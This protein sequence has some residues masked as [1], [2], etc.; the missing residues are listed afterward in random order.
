MRLLVCITLTLV[1]LGTVQ[2]GPV[3]DELTSRRRGKERGGPMPPNSRTKENRPDT[4]DNKIV[5]T[6]PAIGGSVHQ[7]VAMCQPAPLSGRSAANWGPPG[8]A[9]LPYTAVEPMTTDGPSYASML[10]Q[11]ATLTGHCCQQTA[12]ICSNC[13]ARL[14]EAGLDTCECV[15]TATYNVYERIA[16][17]ERRNPGTI[18]KTCIC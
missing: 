4:G 6:G 18:L 11:G 7:C 14:A 5:D 16:E 17:A 15:G 12:E 13:A 10:R 3:D 1:I 9:G 2:A 8:L